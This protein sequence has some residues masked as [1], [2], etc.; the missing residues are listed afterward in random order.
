M[1][2]KYDLDKKDID[3]EVYNFIFP[4][5]IIAITTSFFVG[6][7]G[8]SALLLQG[9]KFKS[10]YKFNGRQ[11]I[12]VSVDNSLYRILKNPMYYTKG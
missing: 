12:Q 10:K 1:R 2:A 6:M 11:S 7:F 9:N 8:E 4:E 5:N 3:V